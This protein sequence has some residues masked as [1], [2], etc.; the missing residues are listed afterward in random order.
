MRRRGVS[1]YPPGR[2]AR[3]RTRASAIC[4]LR[5]KTTSA[6][7]PT[8]ITGSHVGSCRGTTG[9]VVVASSGSKGDNAASTGDVAA[10]RIITGSRCCSSL[11][12]G[13]STPTCVARR[14]VR[15]PVNVGLVFEDAPA[16]FAAEVDRLGPRIGNKHGDHQRKTSAGSHC[17][18]RRHP[19]LP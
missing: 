5:P 19:L 12:S 13:S 10:G 9:G 15:E 2:R 4:S 3:L 1:R 8:V 11:R 16:G 18:P 14:V 6:R 7:L 17:Y